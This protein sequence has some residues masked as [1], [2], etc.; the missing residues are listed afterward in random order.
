VLHTVLLTASLATAAIA[1]AAYLWDTRDERREFARRVE[2][3][4]RIRDAACGGRMP[5][6]R[7]RG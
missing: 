7:I 3:A 5:R 1:F 6:G 4:E 2:R